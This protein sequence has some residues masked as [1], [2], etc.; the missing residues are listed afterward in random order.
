MHIVINIPEYEYNKICSGHFDT[1][2]YFKMNLKE[3]FRN[4]IHLPKG[5]GDLKD[6]GNIQY[7]FDLTREDPIYSGKDIERAIK[8]MESII[9][10]D[11][12]REDKE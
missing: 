3:A 2:G 8:S 6:M 4:A 5:H 12:K 10:A 7:V 9:E 11:K 1:N